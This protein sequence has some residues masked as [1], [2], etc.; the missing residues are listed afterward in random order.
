ME[1]EGAHLPDIL[2]GSQKTLQLHEDL[3][4]RHG[5]GCTTIRECGKSSRLSAFTRQPVYSG[6][7]R[8]PPP[9]LRLLGPELLPSLGSSEALGAQETGLSAAMPRVRPTASKAEER[10]QKAGNG[11]GG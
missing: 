2:L 11:R 7:E 8:P 10:A 6:S 9:P 1:R 4:H 3:A 5:A